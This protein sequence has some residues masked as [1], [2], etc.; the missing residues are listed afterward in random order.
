MSDTPNV[1]TSLMP[2]GS[3]PLLP[4]PPLD[5]DGD[6]I[7]DNY[8]QTP[9]YSIPIEDEEEYVNQYADTEIS[10]SDTE[11]VSFNDIIDNY[12]DTY[13][14]DSGGYISE[15]VQN[16]AIRIYKSYN[17]PKYHNG[18]YTIDDIKTH[19][20]ILA[21]QG[22]FWRYSSI[23][24]YEEFNT[25]NYGDYIIEYLASLGDT[26]YHAMVIEKQLREQ[27]QYVIDTS[28]NE[29][30]ITPEIDLYLTRYEGNL[31]DRIDAD[32]TNPDACAFVYK[33]VKTVAET[34]GSI[35]MYGSPS[36]TRC[37][38]WIQT[39]KEIDVYAKQ[40]GYYFTTANGGGW[41]HGS[42]LSEISNLMPDALTGRISISEQ[43]SAAMQE[44]QAAY[45]ALT[46][47]ETEQERIYQEYIN[48]TYGT[49]STATDT[50]LLVNNLNG[51]YGIPYQFP[52]FVDKKLPTSSGTEGCF[53]QIYADRIISRM[54]LL[55]L[56]PGK[57]DFLSDY[58]DKEKFP[59]IG[60]LLSGNNTE[61]TV[62]SQFI[63][64]PGK[65]YTFSYNANEYWKY[66]NSMNM[67]CAIYLGIGDVILNINGHE[68]PAKEF[69][70]EKATNEKFGNWVVTNE[71]YVCFYADATST[72]DE[73][74]SN[75]TTSSQ[76]ADKVNSFSD[77][78]KEV[79]FVMGAT[80]G[81]K[82]SL[83]EEDNIGNVQAKIDDIANDYLGGSRLFSDLGKDFAV[84]AAGGKLCFPE[85]WSDS[86]FTQSFDVNIK[87]RCPCPNPV[88][89]FLDIIVPLNHL[90]AFVLPRTPYG[91]STLGE[92]FDN[93][94]S[95]Y[96]SPFLVRAFYRGLFNCDMGIITSLSITKGKEGSW[97]LN[98]LP[99]EVDVS[100]TIKD[101]YN[102]MI[103][104]CK[105]TPVTFM[106]NT[107]FLN[108]LSNAC[109]ISV[110]KM[111]IERSIELYYTIYKGKLLNAIT[112]RNFWNDVIQGIQ[113]KALDVY[114]GFFRG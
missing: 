62:L 110:N 73:S 112:G 20:S 79:R 5:T 49:E 80:T 22:S 61:S 97:T 58:T 38:S 88:Q 53:G 42:Y 69:P 91:S 23:Q 85:I 29:G 63:S 66:V 77:L 64:K 27:I 15:T 11:Y 26:S 101:L 55:M 19:L 39:G 12:N 21:K 103:M 100:L 4:P 41:I 114:T 6:G 84:I 104:T 18:E 34:G 109:G 36:N 17:L 30:I 43:D 14:G 82:F 59:I 8:F 9:G 52:A 89:W 102:V 92:Q 87:L 54:P 33:R 86:E 83:L 1:D 3:D 65:Y 31:S 7:A 37:I 67:A 107:C 47:D 94:A 98:G 111:D 10:A 68:A 40:N 50:D 51:I 78:A 113:N 60:A 74:F 13:D 16:D 72:K 48:L 28:T 32:T 71:D 105:D 2:D 93:V 106:S 81:A 25:D 99:T 35:A 75:S 56:S 95:G 45:E 44:A 76:L 108:Y 96:M 90:I 57:V 46:E 70:W 24:S